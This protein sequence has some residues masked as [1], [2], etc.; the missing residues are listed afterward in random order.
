MKYRTGYPAIQVGH[1]DHE[2]W[3]FISFAKELI[4]KKI[5][6]NSEVKVKKRAMCCLM[7][8]FQLKLL[9]VITYKRFEE[10]ITIV[11]GTEFINKSSCS[12]IFMCSW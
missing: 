1:S 8:L 9:E 10:F 12:V 3:K 6:F 4:Y 5:I 11:S 7:L 2:K